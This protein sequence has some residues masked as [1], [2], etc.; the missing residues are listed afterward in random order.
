MASLA[1]S[2]WPGASLLQAASEQSGSEAGN[3]RAAASHIEDVAD[4]AAKKIEET[5][6]K[7]ADKL[8][9]QRLGE[10]IERNVDKAAKK[11]G[12]GL[13][14]TGKKIEEKFGTK[15]APSSTDSSSR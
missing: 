8:E 9:V 7:A 12:E 15:E 13:D 14:K 10:K 1:I 5:F 4:K 2:L 3:E 6:T 11:T